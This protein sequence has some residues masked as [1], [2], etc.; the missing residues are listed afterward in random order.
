MNI[1]LYYL[2]HLFKAVTGITVI[3][4]RNELR[5]TKAKLLLIR[6]DDSIGSIAQSLGFCS[7]AY[8]TEIFTASERIPPSEYRKRHR[9]KETE[10]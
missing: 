7:A 2:S 4:Y 5:L 10:M 8:F 3:D 1:S 9:T 6:T